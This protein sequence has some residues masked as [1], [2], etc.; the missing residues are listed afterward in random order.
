LER[1]TEEQRDEFLTSY[2]HEALHL[3]MRDVYATNIERDRFRKWLDRD[4]PDPAEEAEWWRPWRALMKRNTEE[5]KTLRRLRIVSEPVTDYIR[6]EWLDA[7]ML[8]NAATSRCFS[9]PAMTSGC[10]TVRQ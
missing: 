2:V 8:V 6:F 3:E 7:D 9:C 5:G 4:L 1:I 10:L